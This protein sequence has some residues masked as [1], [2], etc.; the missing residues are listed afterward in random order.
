[1][2]LRVAPDLSL[3]AILELQGDG[4]DVYVIGVKPTPHE[5]VTP[6][7]PRSCERASAS[8]RKAPCAGH[9]KRTQEVEIT[10]GDSGVRGTSAAPPWVNLLS[11]RVR[12]GTTAPSAAAAPAA[13][14]TRSG[15]GAAAPASRG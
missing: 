3:D 6:R 15:P 4:F 10:S 1:M 13:G 14:R 5:A 11:S 2:I 8:S 12:P 9:V 7:H